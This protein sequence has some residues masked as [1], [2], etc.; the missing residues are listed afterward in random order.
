MDILGYILILIMGV[1]LGLLGGGG[2]ILTVPILTYIFSIPAVDATCYSLFIVGLAAGFGAFGKYRE[3]LIDFQIGATFA[4]PGFLGVF[5]ARAY[6]IPAL[7]ESLFSLGSIE[8]TKDVLIMLVFAIM[9]ILASV[10]M[11]R[12]RK[13]VEFSK[14]TTAKK[15]YPLI[16]I[17]GLVVGGLTGFVGAG[18]GFLIIPALV[19]LANLP[20]KTAVGTSLMIISFKSLLG[21]L[22]D[23]FV[24]PNIDWSLLLL[25]SVISVVGILL[26][27]QFSKKLPEKKLKK[28]FGY[29][30]LVMGSFI[31]A[32]QFMG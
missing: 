5:F 30:V 22:G 15:N 23:V 25:L 2:S 10:S 8:V 6:L 14:K 9:M 26:G 31:L 24:N 28:A 19:I 17:E 1:S 12:G 32:K 16:A 7:P 18:G 21:F 29:F 20:M 11:I 3:G 4:V 13:E 27:S